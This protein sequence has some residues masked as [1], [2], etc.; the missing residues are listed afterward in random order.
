VKATDLANNTSAIVVHTWTIVAEPD[1][2]PPTVTITSGPDA[3]TTAT[4]ATFTFTADEPATFYCS[5][6]IAEATECTSPKMYE[7]LA[8]GQHTFAVYAEDAA[9]N[10]SETVSYSWTVI[11]PP[12]TTAPVV[13]ITAMP[14]DPTYD[15]SAT[16]EFSADED[17]TFYCA[18]D[19][20]EF[21]ECTSPV[22]YEDLAL[23]SYTFAV[24]AEDAAGNA[25]EPVSYTWTVVAPPD[26]TAPVVTLTLT[27]TLLETTSTSITFTFTADEEASFECALD[28]ADFAEC[29]SP[30]ELDGLELG[31]HVFRVK[32]TDLAGNTSALVVHTWT[33]VEEPDTTPPTVTITSGPDAETTATSATFEFSADEDA[34]FY[35]SLGIAE[36]TECTSPVVRRPGAG[37]AHLRSL[38][39]GCGGQRERNGQLHLDRRRPARHH[40]PGRDHQ[41]APEDPTY[42]T[43]ATFEF[44]ADEDATFYCSLGI[45]EAT[46]CTS[47]KTY[48]ELDLGEHTLAVYAVDA[49]GNQSKTVSY[50]WTVVAPP[51]TTAP[52]VTLEATPDNP[53]Y[54]TSA[55]FAFSADEEAT[56]YCSLGI[57]EATECTSPVEYEDLA[58]GEHT[59]TVYAVDAAG[60]QSDTVSYTWT[61]VAPPDTTAPVVNITAMPDDPTYDTSATFEF[62]ADEDATFYCAL[63]NA[64]FAECT[65]PVEYEDLALGSYTFAVYAE[66]A[67]GNASE[68]VSYTWT[69]VAP[70]DTTAPVVTLTA[71]PVELSTTST[72]ISFT[73]TADE[74]ASFECALDAADFAE[75]TSPVVLEDLELGQRVFRVKATDLANNTSAPVVHTWTIVEE[76]DETAPVVT[77]EAMP[78][79]PTYETSATFEFSADED[80]AFYCALDGAAAAECSSPVEY[81][82]L[83]LGSHTFSVSAVDLAGNESETVSYTWTIDELP[84]TTA[85]IVTITSAPNASTEATSATFEFSADEDATFYCSLG[86]A[87]ATECSS[88]KTYDELASA[89]TPSQSTPWTR[90]RTRA[91]RLATPGPSSPRPTPL[92]RQ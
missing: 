64:E 21:A 65:S 88:P 90:R 79:D 71:D 2:T 85:P 47:P 81:E 50:T 17:A 40:R 32:A 52:T 84:D 67:A 35:C 34:T 59:F 26:T 61:V 44:S 28:V 82:D 20:A 86:I 1:T 29:T 9:G 3:E 36:A 58:L 83:A 75:C 8:L 91:N 68:P 55:T 24:Y 73:F 18:L 38:R 54:A 4:S 33:I 23:G 87:E 62:S 77:L 19:N 92:R 22:E 13:N 45:A 72:S 89:S 30:V 78:E 31:Q 37:P 60:N 69:V 27:R 53:T 46:E 10:V 70:P 5:L 56:F 74:E 43:S 15:T 51:D 63:D 66:D 57:A 48:D 39:R 80:A 76:P 12:D 6:G 41:V 7:D 42:D 16:F 14:D 49:A 11:A 25:S